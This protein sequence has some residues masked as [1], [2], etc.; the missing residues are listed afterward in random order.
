VV[1]QYRRLA[2][3]LHHL[4]TE[5]GLKTLMVTS[6]MPSDGKTLTVTN[7]VIINR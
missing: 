2:S 5:A 3:S 6:A 7:P 4:Q 1:E